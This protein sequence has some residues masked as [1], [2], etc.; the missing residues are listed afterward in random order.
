MAVAGPLESDSSGIGALRALI[1]GLILTLAQIVFACLAGLYAEGGINA[2]SAEIVRAYAR[3]AQFDSQWHV[4]IADE[5]YDA[6]KEFQKGVL[7]NVAFFPAYPLLVRGVV[8]ITGLPTA[9]CLL[10]VAQLACWGFWTYFF[11][12]LDDH[13]V[14]PGN[15]R[16]LALVI[17]SQPAAFFL[18]AGYADSLF[19]FSLLGYIYWS[20]SARPAFKWLGAVHGFLMTATRIIG[21]PLVIYPVVRALISGPRSTRKDRLFD[22]ALLAALSSM[23][24]LA[25]LGYC[26][27]T[28]GAWDLTLITR[29]AGWHVKPD[30]MALLNPD[31]YLLDLVLWK[32]DGF[33]SADWLSRAHVPALLTIFALL[34]SV[35]MYVA[36]TLPNSTFADRFTYFIVAFVLFGFLVAGLANSGFRS[37]IRYILPCEVLLVLQI[38]HLSTDEDLEGSDWAML[39]LAGVVIVPSFVVQAVFANRFL[40]G[41]WVA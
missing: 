7:G 20:E 13:N 38:A 33:V 14:S 30:A 8:E 18:V 27:Q 5:G 4:W 23:G 39:G 9:L 11:L 25:F 15:A 10:I 19:L 40:N 26:H 41:L 1:S 21:L 17:T 31:N 12:L 16:I 36:S 24:G 22:A 34:F 37:L 28:F 2:N 32:T 3:L 29:Q 6:D 35:E